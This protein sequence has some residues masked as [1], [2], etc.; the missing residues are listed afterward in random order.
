MTRQSIAL[1]ISL[2]VSCGEAAPPPKAPTAIAPKASSARAPQNPLASAGAASTA[3]TS[4][5]TNAVRPAAS[6][7]PDFGFV[8]TASSDASKIEIAGLVMPK[9][10]TWTWEAPSMQFRVLQYAVPANAGE[11]GAAELVF[12]VFA[13]GDGGPIDA[14]IKRWESQFRTD[15]GQSASAQVKEITVGVFPI[16]LVEL[17]GNYQGMGQ[18]APRPGIMQLA[19]ILQP[20]GKTIFVRLVGP[21]A[22][23]ESAR[24]QFMTMIEGA[25][26]AP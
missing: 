5:T 4:S 2:L 24:A 14:N 17:A 18:A 1:C 11:S 3:S 12:S 13:A 20:P 15:D 25:R 7:K 16:R 8:S 21:S 19:G 22:T 6:D 26:P 10:P 9:P 23:V